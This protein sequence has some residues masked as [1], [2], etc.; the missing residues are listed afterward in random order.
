MKKSILTGVLLVTGA[1]V[2]LCYFLPQSTT[3]HASYERISVSSSSDSTPVTR[4]STKIIDHDDN[5]KT[6]HIVIE[7]GEIKSLTIDG[8][9][10]EKADFGK[11]QSEIAAIEPPP[12]PP[13]PP[14]PP[15]PPVPPVKEGN[16]KEEHYSKRV[17]MSAPKRGEEAQNK[18]EKL[19]AYLE[20]TGLIKEGENYSIQL[21]ENELRIND[22]V[23]STAILSKCKEILD[24]KK[25]K[26][27]I[28][29]NFKKTIKND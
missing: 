5:G 13:L 25:C 9:A 23:Q 6:K 28:N 17:E 27:N 19:I 8:K 12:L 26:V 16:Y 4:I 14:I 18:G 10:I 21:D 1:S 7:N 11:Y 22:A 20:S 24:C 29:S 15:V 3:S 2:A